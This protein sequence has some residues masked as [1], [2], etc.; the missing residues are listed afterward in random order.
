LP[1]E[2]WTEEDLDLLVAK[3]YELQQ[4]YHYNN[5]LSA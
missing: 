5:R 3:A 2:D 1:T 4:L